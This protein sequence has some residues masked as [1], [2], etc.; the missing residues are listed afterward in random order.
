MSVKIF[1]SMALD[2]RTSEQRDNDRKQH[3]QWIKEQFKDAEILDTYITAEPPEGTKNRP[4]WYF[5]KGIMEH[6]SIADYLVVPYNWEDVRGVRCEKYI[7][8]QYGVP[9]V[10]MPDFD[11]ITLLG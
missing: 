7:A 3:H 1:H 8:E 11:D 4:L 10:V 6:L 5:G 2:G 9:V